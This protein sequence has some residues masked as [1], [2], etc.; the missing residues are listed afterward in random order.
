MSALAKATIIAMLYLETWPDDVLDP[1]IALEALED[2]TAQLQDCS[3]SEQADL[4]R[5]V[6]ELKT[7]E[8]AGSARKDIIRF[9][10]EFM[11]A[12]GFDSAEEAKPP[13]SI[14]KPGKPAQKK[15]GKRKRQ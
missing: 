1:D 7:A 14:K 9:Y 5:A 6:A 10:N 15:Q 13:K 3:K 12:V 11:E 8:K 2:I 4:A